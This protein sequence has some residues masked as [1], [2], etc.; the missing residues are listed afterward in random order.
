MT[1]MMRRSRAVRGVTRETYAIF[2]YR[3]PVPVPS[4]MPVDLDRLQRDL[5]AIVGPRRVSMRT[6]DLET[7]S[8]DMWPRLLLAYR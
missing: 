3:S 5:E 4:A 8:R 2:E 6:V 7:Y 1:V